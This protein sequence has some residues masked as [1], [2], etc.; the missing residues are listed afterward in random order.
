MKKLIL[1]V[2]LIN[3]LAGC[4]YFK[5]KK[6]TAKVED[7]PVATAPAPAGEQQDTGSA[8]QADVNAQTLASDTADSTA[9]T[10]NTPA[11]VEQADKA[12]VIEQ[13]SDNAAVIEQPKR[14][15]YFPFDVDSIQDADKLVVQA[16]GAYLGEHPEQKVRTEGHADERGSSE[17]NLALGQ[18]RANN[19]KKALVLSGAK[20]KQVDAIS[21]G[22]EKPQSSGHDENSW[23]QNRRVDI[24]Y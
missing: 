1:S 3:L 7:T 5:P 13:P 17:Y 12:A 21:F 15:V 20:A 18:R 11:P 6:P 2:V 23:A 8:T 19:T 10:G 4:S 22:E 9:T 14:S 16:H 24:S